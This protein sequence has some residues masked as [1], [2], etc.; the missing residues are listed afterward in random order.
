VT[1]GICI[2][3]QLMPLTLKSRYLYPV[4]FPNLL[5]VLGDRCPEPHWTQ[6]LCRLEDKHR[7][8]LIYL[9]IKSHEDYL[10]IDR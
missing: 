9:M 8:I 6:Q 2:D 4:V 10:L 1:Q 5:P 3:P 7:L